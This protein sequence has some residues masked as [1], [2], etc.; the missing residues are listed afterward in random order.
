VGDGGGA[1]IALEAEL[2]VAGQVVLHGVRADLPTHT[3][4]AE[5]GVVDPAVCHQLNLAEGAV[6]RYDRA[7]HVLQNAAARCRDQGTKRISNGH[8]R[9]GVG[10][11]G[12][13][14]RSGEGPAV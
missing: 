12:G 8:V 11:E 10:R 2:N 9:G 1:A 5:G 7:T 3:E 14:A 13:P 4:R 6:G